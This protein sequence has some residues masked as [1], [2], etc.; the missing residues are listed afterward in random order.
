MVNNKKVKK[1]RKEKLQKELEERKAF[2]DT[3]VLKLEELGIN[4]PEQFTAVH[5]LLRKLKIF[6]DTGVSE[7][8]KI[9]FPEFNRH[10]QYIFTNSKF[11]EGGVSLLSNNNITNTHE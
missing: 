2:A 4:D 8:G 9:P 6:V 1:G 10:F 3:V 11:K 5:E 7:S